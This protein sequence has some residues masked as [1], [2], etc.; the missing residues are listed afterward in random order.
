MRPPRIQAPPPASFQR[1]LRVLVIAAALV[2]VAYAWLG[3]EAGA[4]VG[5]ADEPLEVRDVPRADAPSLARVDATLLAEVADATPLERSRLEAQPLAHLLLQAGRLV[6]GDIARLGAVPG[7]WQA[8]VERGAE[9]RG[10]PVTVL[11]TLRWTQ[12]ADLGGGQRV[13][14]ELSDEAGRPWAFVLVTEPWDV[15]PGDVVKL[16]GFSFKA[17]E[18]LRPDGSQVTA[19][20]VVADELLRSAFPLA[21]VT[22][23]LAGAFDGLR[24]YDLREAAAPLESPELWTLMSYVAHTDVATLFPPDQPLPEIVP[25]ELLKRPAEFR[26]RP[27]TITGVLY[28]LAQ[29]P[30]GPRGENPLGIPFAWHLWLSDN[31]AGGA[32]MVLALSTTPP[33][34]LAVG[35]IVEVDGLFL[36]RWSFENR[37]NEVR[38]ASVVV[39][40]RVRRFVPAPDTLKPVLV[41]A[42][43]V[44]VGGLGL[45]FAIAQ[46]RERRREQSARSDR[47]RRHQENLA[48]PGRLAARPG[49]PSPP[50]GG[51]VARTGPP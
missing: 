43:F 40:S 28:H 38:L 27:V 9:H 46:W 3:D 19:P 25:H 16:E 36:R 22:E 44:L 10:Q 47:M 33:G 37:S 15:T 1:R 6:Y 13:R 51:R 45:A 50:S 14:G 26:A 21:P 48:R 34:G 42:I 12:A 41:K 32:G 20:L 11:G 24:D 4:P 17:H 7:D 31:R 49:E 5:L 18:L 39:A 2:A 23:L 8:L 35:D 30:L 29:E